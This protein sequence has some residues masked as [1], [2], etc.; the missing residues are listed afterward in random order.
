MIFVMTTPEDREPRSLDEEAMVGLYYL[1]DD[2]DWEQLAYQDFPDVASVV[3]LSDAEL[4]LV[5]EHALSMDQARELLIEELT[6]WENDYAQEDEAETPEWAVRY[7]QRCRSSTGG[8]V[9]R[10]GRKR[11]H[12]TGTQR[13]FCT[14]PRLHERARGS[15]Q[16]LAPFSLARRPLAGAPLNFTGP[17]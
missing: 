3:K 1:N 11:G 4:Q 15:D 16:C 9:S 7:L 12:R 13:F 5:I 8:R 17:N 2:G 14:D 10:C 6:Y